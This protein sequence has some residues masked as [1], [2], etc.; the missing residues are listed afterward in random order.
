MIFFCSDMNQGIE[1]ENNIEW[2]Q[3]RNYIDGNKT[4]NHGIILIFE[5]LS[6]IL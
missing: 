6:M 4:S 2:T 3:E 1:D 5:C